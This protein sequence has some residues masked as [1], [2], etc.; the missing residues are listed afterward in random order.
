MLES[1]I[2]FEHFSLPKKDR[3]DFDKNKFLEYNSNV[4]SSNKVKKKER[5]CDENLSNR[6]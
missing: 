4:K 5:K 2:G 3:K 1:I 6:W